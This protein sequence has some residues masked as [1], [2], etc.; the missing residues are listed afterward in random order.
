MF[1]KLGN[2]PNKP[3]ILGQTM[4]EESGLLQFRKDSKNYH[5]KSSVLKLDCI[6]E[7]RGVNHCCQLS[8]LKVY[9]IP[10]FHQASIMVGRQLIYSTFLTSS[11]SRKVLPKVR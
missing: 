3:G 10:K 5:T 7:T 11:T 6:E 1:I 8:W 2:I 9:S 4:C